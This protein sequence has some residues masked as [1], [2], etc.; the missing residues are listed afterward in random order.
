[1]FVVSSV[2][3]VLAIPLGLAQP[4]SAAEVAQSQVVSDNPAN[5]TPHVLDGDVNSIAQ[6][7][8][9]IVLGGSFTQVSNAQRTQTY[10]RSNVVA[11]DATTGVIDTAFNPAPDGTVTTVLPSADG[12]SVYLGGSFNSVSGETRRKVARV[13]I[14]TGQNTTG[15]RN[16]AANGIV[17]DL[18]LVGN[19]LWVAGAFT[20]MSGSSQSSLATLNATTGNADAY[21]ALSVAGQHNGGT[22]QVTKIDVTADGS[23]LVGIGNFLTVGGQSRQQIFMLDI[24]GDSAALAD[25]QTDFYTA[26]C[27][28]SFNTYM[29]DLDF[30]PDGSFFVVTTTGA[31]LG[32]TSPCDTQARF[33]TD[34][35]GSGVT[36]E[37]L[38]TTGGDTTYAVEVTGTAVYVG[39]HFRWANNSFSGDSAG[40]GAIARE[41]IA[42]LDP[43]NGMPLSWNPGRDRGVGVFDML[44]TDTGLWVGSD[45]E[46][47]GGE[48][49]ARVAFFPLAGGTTVPVAEAPS[50]P[51][52]II[53]L[54]PKADASESPVLYRI[55][56]AGPLVSSSDSGPD[57]AA[58]TADTSSVRVGG[59]N[60]ATYDPSVSLDESVP[61]G[62][63]V[64]VFD[65]ERWDDDGSPEMQWALPV[66][67][68]APIEVRLYF[69]NRYSGTAEEGDRVFDVSVDGSLVLDDFDIVAAAG[70]TDIG[71]MR[72]VELVSD[73]TV[74]IDFGHVVENPLVNAIEIIRTDVEAVDMATWVRTTQF[75]GDE[76]GQTVDVA[77]AGDWTGVRGGFML[78][79][80]VYL[81]YS[82][83]D[84]VRRSYDGTTWGDAVSV[85]TQDEIVSLSDWHTNVSLIT[86]VFYDDGRMYYTQSGDDSLRMRYLTT[87]NDAVGALEY[88]A[89]ESIEGLDLSQVRG[90]FLAGDFVFAVQPDGSLTRVG[91]QDG[92]FVSGSATSVSGP[93][94]DGKNWLAGAL[95][96]YQSADGS[97]PNYPP[98]A[99]IGVECENQACEFTSDG[100]SDAGGSIASY[101][102]DFGDGETSTQ[103][104]PSHT[105]AAAGTY[106]ITLTVTD[107]DGATGSASTTQS[108]DFLDGLPTGSFEVSCAS[109]V[110]SFDGSGS[111]DA[112]GSIADYAWDFGDGS[113]G[114]GAEV[115]HTFAEDGEYDVTLTVTDSAGQT[116]EVTETVEVA[117]VSAVIEFVGSATSNRNSTTHPT[118]VPAATQVG[119]VMVLL[120]T[121]NLSSATV[122]APA[123]WTEVAAATSSTGSVTGRAWTKVATA[124]DLGGQVTPTSSSAVK[125]AATLLVY[126][127]VDSA[128]PVAAVE[129]AFESVSGTTHTT[130]QVAGVSGGLLVS[131]WGMKGNVADTL[132]APESVTERA[133]SSGS[134]NGNITAL[135]ADSGPLSSGQAGGVTATATAASNKAFLLSLVLN[136]AG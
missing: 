96:A 93:A 36:P 16:V 97:V 23:R 75:S 32:S 39:G 111:S 66:E 119:D 123:G 106:S 63:P 1:M 65:Q 100:S 117:T 126:R 110:C 13:D 120:Y 73:G 94:I 78:N 104:N 29:R 108:V 136:P 132:T 27:S 129:S 21:M 5:Y 82:N 127:G 51:T 86:G 85:D 46:W 18:R 20:S 22:T 131:Y 24:S 55:N 58:D 87:Q 4:A 114:S 70:G 9:L 64:S 113:D 44:A 79:G 92:A 6:V 133:S 105:Y 60:V 122:S 28:S 54:A 101:L 2:I 118:A 107:N 25:W 17:K 30:A 3:A 124:S 135:A 37:W 43:E 68:G 35:T 116:A 41:G 134:S 89:S 52:N 130:P 62:T 38:N 69:A 121:N 71:I 99:E 14:A 61:T 84:F 57:W 7:G 80:N 48:Y 67:E 53:S 115:S 56:A 47:I 11:F 34:R 83:G 50:L 8:N 112:E 77:G 15:F 19:R 33:D 81:S 91:W 76:V 102:W 42:A 31:Y 125:A 59:T 10:Q 95:F 128:D 45:T 74:N 98:T 103:A 49:H 12:N 109:L 88:V 90:M 26:T 40:A 72:S